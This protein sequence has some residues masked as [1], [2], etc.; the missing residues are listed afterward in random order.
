MRWLALIGL[1]SGC[2]LVDPGRCLDRDRSRE[3]TTAT[4]L[5]VGP[6]EQA[7]VQIDAVQ[8]ETEEPR[9]SL[10]WIIQNGVLGGN[11]TALSLYDSRDGRRLVDLP[12]SSGTQLVGMLAP[13]VGQAPFGTL[14][15]ALRQGVVKIRIETDLPGREAVDGVLAVARFSDWAYPNCS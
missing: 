13:Y 8:H 15:G 11:V 3:V 7:Y 12:L 9:E 1:L 10:S 2:G 14:F 6:P 5:D 4:R